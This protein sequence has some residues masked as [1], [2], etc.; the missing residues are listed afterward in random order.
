M[1]L[2]AGTNR[3]VGKTTFICQLIKRLSLKQPVIAIKIT[4]HFH[5]SCQ[6]CILLFQSQNLVI[7]EEKSSTSSKDSSKMLDAGASKV[8]YIQGADGELNQVIEILKPIIPRDVALVCESAA[9][10]KLVKPGLFVV[11]SKEGEE[12]KNNEMVKLSD[13]YIKDFNYQAGEFSFFNRKWK[14]D[15]MKENRPSL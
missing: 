7:T 1:L 3:N 15:G 14:F 5:E 12:V 9:L 13:V 4:P 11:L 2:V 6:S 10:R 8:F